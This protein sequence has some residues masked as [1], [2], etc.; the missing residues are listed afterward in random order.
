M[1]TLSSTHGAAS[2]LG[3]CLVGPNT[4]HVDVQYHD[5]IYLTVPSARMIAAATA[6]KVSAERT[7]KRACWVLGGTDPRVTTLAYAMVG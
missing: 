5:Q 3:H 7:W 6:E 2:F 1:L 4:G